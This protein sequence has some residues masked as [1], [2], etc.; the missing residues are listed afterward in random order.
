[1]QMRIRPAV[2]GAA[3]ILSAFVVF[4]ERARLYVKNK[5]IFFFLLRQILLLNL[6]DEEPETFREF[7]NIIF[8]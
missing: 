3:L 5:S 6:M 2:A 8:A 4:Q 1:M 7:S